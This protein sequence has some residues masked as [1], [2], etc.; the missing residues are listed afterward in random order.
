MTQYGRWGWNIS[1]I[2]PMYFAKPDL[3]KDP[4]GVRL[5][6]NQFAIYLVRDEVGKPME[7][8]ELEFSYCKRGITWTSGKR[9]GQFFLNY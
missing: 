1:G 5:L 8:I 2:E 4:Y 7:H 6:T 3:E 9:K